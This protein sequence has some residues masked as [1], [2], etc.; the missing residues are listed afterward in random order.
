LNFKF[1]IFKIGFH[2]ELSWRLKNMIHVTWHMIKPS[3]F[4]FSLFLL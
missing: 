2:T 1:G 4:P 3:N